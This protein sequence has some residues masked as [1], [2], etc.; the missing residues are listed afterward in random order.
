MEFLGRV[1]AAGLN[2]YGGEEL[3]MEGWG[4]LI[5]L[6]V[7]LLGEREGESVLVTGGK[8]PQC[9]QRYEQRHI[10]R[11]RLVL[12]HAGSDWGRRFSDVGDITLSATTTS[13]HNQYIK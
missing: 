5:R 3:Q 2:P 7:A 9:C 1:K 8:R 4:K 13:N 6:L 12:P 11:S 10:E